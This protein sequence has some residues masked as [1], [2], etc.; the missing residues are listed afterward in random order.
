MVFVSC[1]DLKD[2]IHSPI[3]VPFR[4][5]AKHPIS[6]VTEVRFEPRTFAGRTTPGGTVISDDEDEFCSEEDEFEVD[7]VTGKLR[8]VRV[9]TRRHRPRLAP[10]QRRETD[11]AVY[12]GVRMPRKDQ[13]LQAHLQAIAMNR[14]KQMARATGKGYGPDEIFGLRTSRPTFSY[15]SFLPRY[16]R[17][18]DLFKVDE[19]RISHFPRF[20]ELVAGGGGKKKKKK[21]ANSLPPLK[22]TYG[23]EKPERYLPRPLHLTVRKPKP[24]IETEADSGPKL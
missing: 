18:V 19:R 14:T 7:P 23:D 1:E 17:G 9:K 3:T 16:A 20:V 11:S 21:K 6:N 8:R 4:S 2:V 22:L 5:L 10:G 12:E 15:F 24:R 13:Y